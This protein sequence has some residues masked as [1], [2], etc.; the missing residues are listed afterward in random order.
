MNLPYIH[1]K[2]LEFSYQNGALADA[3]K[4]NKVVIELE[5]EVPQ[6]PKDNC[7]CQFYK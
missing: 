6:A 4:M 3:W 5:I 7:G 2:V 1:D